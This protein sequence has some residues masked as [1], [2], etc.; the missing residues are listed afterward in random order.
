MQTNGS[1]AKR[2]QRLIE[3]TKAIPWEADAKTWRFT[4][5]GPQAEKQLGYPREK[6]Y[7]SNF[8]VDHIHPEDR[9]F[10][11]DYCL[12]AS[13]QF[14]D[15]DFDYRM[16]DSY[17]Q[18][19]WL[20]DIVSVVRENGEPVT[21]I[22]F[23]ID[24]SAKKRVEEAL[25]NLSARLINAQEEERKRVAR[26]LHDDFNQRLAL[27]MI[28]LEQLARERARSPEDFDVNIRELLGRIKELTLDVHRLSHR[29]HPSA[30]VHL[31]LVPAVKSL[32]EE[33]SA[34]HDIRIHFTCPEITAPV[35]KDVALC[36]YRIVQEALRNIIKH[37][38]ALEAHVALARTKKGLE[39][40]VCDQ[41]AGFD[42]AGVGSRSGLGLISMRER[43]RLLGG[44][45]AI[46]SSAAH[47]TQIYVLVPLSA[48]DVV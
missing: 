28:D 33:L 4:Y 12:N 32:C 5:V 8:W 29:L 41:G 34:L 23:M 22:G 43:L 42:V 40:H 15:Y 11:I 1:R 45:I 37:S 7:E 36:C 39:M 13:N 21:L 17:G 47:G 3:S 25:Q 10:T 35:P 6:W 9:E 18:S 16:I 48:A 2:L 19:V 26:E 38:G 27:V 24:I 44:Q 31:G 30:L 14:L 20:H 46:K